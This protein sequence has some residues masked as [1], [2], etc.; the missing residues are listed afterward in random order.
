MRLVLIDFE[1]SNLFMATQFFEISD[2]DKFLEVL[3][4]ELK[5]IFNPGERIAVKL[6]MGEPG[7]K[8]RLSIP[9]VKGIVDILLKL[10]TKPFLFDSPVKYDSPRNTEQGY[11]KAAKAEGWES[12]G[13]PVVVSNESVQLKGKYATYGVCKKLIEADGVLVLTHVKGHECT[14]FGASIKNLGMGALSKETKT[15]IHHGGEPKYIGNCQMC[16]EC[17]RACPTDNIRY[18]NNRPYFDKNWCLGCSNCVLSCKYNAIKPNLETFDKL[19]ADGAVTAKNSFKKSYFVNVI[20]NL[21]QMCDCLSDPGKIV[22]EDVGFVI[23]D[24][25]TE[26]DRE[27]FDRINQ[28][29]DKDIFLEVNKKSP[30][31]HI[32]AAEELDY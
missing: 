28:K 2:E 10:G 4:K 29:A 20:N 7:N 15:M 32:K 23:G 22:M 19:L 12:V 24:K 8:T 25:L 21:T 5:N 9:F 31:I 6:H 11:L 1:S 30:L 16:G 18:E 13:C 26:V 3:K 17:A 27:S 14:G